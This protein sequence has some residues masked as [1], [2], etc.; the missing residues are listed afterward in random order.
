M[1]SIL[2]F[3]FAIICLSLFFGCEKTD[4]GTNASVNYV[5]FE[6][7]SM[8]IGVEEGGATTS[9]IK[10]FTGNV[11]NSNRDISVM[12]VA[13]A[14]DADPASYSVP[15][16]VS[17]PAGTNEGVLTI[18]VQD[19]G[20]SDGDKSLTLALGPA[21][22]I[23]VGSDI[24]ISLSQ[25]CPNNGTKVGVSLTFDNWP[26]EVSW[27]ITDSSGAVVMEGSPNHVPY[28]GEYQNEASGS[29]LSITPMCL[30]AGDYTLNVSDD[31][32]DG[33]TTFV[34]TGNGSQIG[35]LDGGAYGASGSVSFTL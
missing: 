4:D 6:V 1:K 20:L 28:A 23:S 17:I 9:D 16:T 18:N 27:T 5:T 25:V 7:P 34:I 33:G 31:Y 8:T 32:G 26:E 24:S 2:K 10:L 14:T 3:S 12:V 35:G 21:D 30:D 11:T 22:V 15:A 19:V 29:T 13:D